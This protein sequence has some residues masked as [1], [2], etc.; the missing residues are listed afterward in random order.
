MDKFMTQVVET[1]IQEALDEIAKMT[2]AVVRT[3][4]VNLIMDVAGHGANARVM[5]QMTA[6]ELGLDVD[7]DPA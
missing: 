2:Q 6:N 3:E 7:M 1:L 4:N 5:L